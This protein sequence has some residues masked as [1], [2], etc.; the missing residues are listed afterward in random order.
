MVLNKSDEDLEFNKIQN[1]IRSKTIVDKIRCYMLYQFAKQIEDLDGEV[2]EVGVYK[3]G[4]AKLISKVLTKKQIYL[5]DTF[6]GMPEVD[7]SKDKH[8]LGDFN[9]TTLENTKEFL[10]DCNNVNFYKGLFPTTA[11]HMQDKK[12]CFV[13]VDADIYK[14]VLDCCVFFYDK[15]VIGAIVVFDDYGFPTCPGA[16]RAVDEFFENKKEQI[17]YLQ[18]GQ[19][20]IIK[21]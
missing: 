18:T 13:H 8:K 20:F 4:T 11:K 15:L 6:E 21:L 16:K 9:D 7:E 10:R 5:F 1:E 14:S 12:F 3:G 17:I 2:A 19:C